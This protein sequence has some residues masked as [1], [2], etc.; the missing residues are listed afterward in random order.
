MK[1]VSLT[2]LLAMFDASVHDQILAAAEK[3]QSTHIV[4]FE[5]QAFDSSAFG[6]RSAV[7]VGP[8]NTYQTPAD[9]EGHWLNDLPSQRQYPVCF[10]ELEDDEEQLEG[11]EPPV[12]PRYD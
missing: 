12:Y 8:N 5:N 3:H 10:A 11:R 1:Q 2:E 7:V 6:A 4:C 9:C